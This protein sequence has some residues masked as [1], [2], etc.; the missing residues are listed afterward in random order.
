MKSRTWMW[1]TAVSL[2]AALTMPVC[3]AAQNNPTQDHK[4]KHHQYKLI[5]LGTLGGPTSFITNLET[6]TINPQGAAIAEA[7][8]AIPDPYYPNCFQDCL[9]NHS[10][11]WQNGV[12]TDLGALPGVNSSIPFWINDRGWT[13]GMSENGVTDPLTGF[14]ETDAVLWRNGQIINL[15]T[16]GGNV[17]AANAVNNRGQVV[18]GAL[19][20]IPDPFSGTFFPSFFFFPVATQ[21][22]AFLWQNGAMQDLGTLGGPDSVAWFVNEPGQIAGQ[23]SINFVPNPGTGI[24]TVDPFFWE[25]GKMVDIGGLGGTLGV[26]YDLNNRGQVVGQSNLAGDQTYHPFLWDKRAGLKDLGTLGGNL[27]FSVW[28]NDAGVVVGRADISIGSNAHHAFRWTQATGMQDLGAPG[29]DM[30]STAHAINSSGQIVGTSAVQ[31]GGNGCVGGCHGWL[32]ED[33]GPIV[34]LETLVLP[35]SDLTIT[36]VVSI[37]DRGEVTGQ[38]ILANGDQH[39]YLAIPCDDKHPG[40]CLDY[41]MIEV[42]TPQTSGPATISQGSESP[43]GTDNPSRNRFGRGYHLPGQPAAPRD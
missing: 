41:S 4:S 16:L 33:G 31:C 32:W 18:G 37:N 35:G 12:L 1:M 11:Q 8:T 3:M 29:N 26:V 19:N 22:H 14:P 23:S 15:G 10:G 43:A 5:D 34:D 17:S 28:V 6:D 7:D 21:S 25:N 2:F 13:T 30:C 27:G 36:G 24:P 42:S 9:V 38:G 20:T 40:Q 39:A